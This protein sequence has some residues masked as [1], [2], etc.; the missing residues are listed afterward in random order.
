MSKTVCPC[1]K[2]LFKSTIGI[3]MHWNHSEQCRAFS[4]NLLKSS[5]ISSIPSISAVQASS[6]VHQF[7]CDEQEG[8]TVDNN[9]SIVVYDNAMEHDDSDNNEKDCTIKDQYIN[10]KREMKDMITI[11]MAAYKSSVDL[12]H[13]LK[14]CNTPLYM[15]DM[16]MEWA[17]NARWVHQFSFLKEK[18]PSRESF[19]DSL[20]NQFD[21]KTL[22]PISTSIELPG[23][24][25]KINLISH[26]FMQC[27]YSLL[28]DQHLMHYNNLLI[29]PENIFTTYHSVRNDHSILSDVNSGDVWK[30]AQKEYIRL[31]Q[32][33]LLCPIIFF[34]DKTHT[35][36]NGRLCIE[37]IRFTLGIFKLHIRNQS[38]SWRTLGYIMDQSQISTNTSEEKI[39]DYHVMTSKILQ[40]FQDAQGKSIAWN[41]VVMDKSIDV[42]FRIPVLFIIGDTDGHDKIVGK[43]ANRSNKVKRLCRYCDCP[44]DCTDDPNYEFRLNKKS[45]ILRLIKKKNVEELR[46]M[47]FHC[48]PNAW[49]DILF[50]DN[51]R[52]IYGATPAEIMHCLQKGLFEYIVSVLFSQKQIKK[53][54]SSKRKGK[55]IRMQNMK[56][57]RSI[58]T[59]PKNKE[60]TD[61]I[62]DDSDDIS[63]IETESIN[64]VNRLP[65]M[66]RRNVFTATYAKRFDKLTRRYG[67]YLMHQ[68]NRDLP[69]THFYTN[70]TSTGY[71][72]ASELTGMLIVFLM[73]FA[74]KEGENILDASLGEE[75]TSKYI[76]LFEVMLM[77]E[78]FCKAE[79]HERGMVY[80][81]KQMVPIILGYYKTTLN[82]QEGN[83]MKI[84]KFHL[85]LHFADDILRFGS[86]ANFDSSIGESHHKDFAKKPSKNTQR[87]KEIFE[88]QTAKRQI[89]NLVIDR[90]YDSIYPDARYQ[91]PEPKPIELVSMNK[92]YILE[93]CGIINNIVYTNESKSKNR[94]IC[95]WKDKVF[96][97][98]LLK[99]LQKAIQNG[100]LTPPIKFFTQHNRSGNIFRADPQFNKKTKEPWYDW[101]IVNWGEEENNLVP[102]KL[103]LFMELKEEDFNGCFKFGESYIEAPGSYAIAYSFET[104]VKEPA[105]LDSRLVTYGKL[106]MNQTTPILYVFDVNCIVDTCIAVPYDPE[107]CIITGT[108]WLLLKSKEEWYEVFTDFM[109]ETLNNEDD[110]SSS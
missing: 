13:V 5:Q 73:V 57:N 37:Q 11:P 98:Q 3:Q 58:K 95:A 74:T 6:N 34:I 24:N 70:Y 47:S 72:N 23:S 100:H 32:S 19:V 54:K 4:L 33:E 80:K 79:R 71:K 91:K 25:T 101:V 106:L 49:A 61:D 10:F 109:V 40:S 42:F 75:R 67:K 53:Q 90:A 44:F 63:I 55:D 99:E 20:K 28:S 62:S 87:R 77:M 102:A 43:F 78:N 51:K 97:R 52:G 104:N 84:I 22:E 35:D 86:M 17:S 68:S 46:D 92:N 41:L 16:I 60:D 88:E 110:D 59:M 66:S 81:F 30:M 26:D 21:Y 50:C 93:Y 89:D 96:S 48:V 39:L 65:E 14:T 2:G 31:G 12:L 36:L 107:E 45:T 82:R 69:R 85:P 29:D 18:I 1:C 76:H 64:D 27:F 8:R 94:P 83:Q 108:K 9:N 38:R 7:S 56:R 15:F 103:L 105:H